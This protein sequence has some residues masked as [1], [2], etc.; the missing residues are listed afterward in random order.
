MKYS[1]LISVTYENLVVWTE[2]PR[3]GGSIPPPGTFFIGAGSEEWVG[4]FFKMIRTRFRMGSVYERVGLCVKGVNATTYGG[5]A[6][7]IRTPNGSGLRGRRQV[8]LCLGQK[9][10]QT[11]PLALL[12]L[13][14]SGCTSTHKVIRVFV[15]VVLRGRDLRIWVI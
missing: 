6:G 11:R 8:G 3:V 13:L 1:F 15:K 5:W 9:I 4:S 14:K 12:S 10:G 7:G 2:N